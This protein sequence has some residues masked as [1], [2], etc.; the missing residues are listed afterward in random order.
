M[1]TGKTRTAIELCNAVADLQD[2]R[3]LVLYFRLRSSWSTDASDL[4]LLAKALTVANNKEL[5]DRPVTFGE[6]A[7]AVRRDGFTKVILHMDE[8][9]LDRPFISR[10][11]DGCVQTM[12]DFRTD[13]VT[14]IP[15]LSGIALPGRKTLPS[16]ESIQGFQIRP[17]EKPEDLLVPFAD[18]INVPTTCVLSSPHLKELLYL[19][20]GA[21]NVVEVMTDVIL[22]E[23]KGNSTFKADLQ[24]NLEQQH[25]R[26]VYERTLLDLAGTYGPMRWHSLIVGPRPDIVTDQQA[27]DRDSWGKRSIHVLECLFLE[28]FMGS[29]IQNADAR[30]GTTDMTDPLFP[31]YRDCV[32]AG[33]LSI[34]EFTKTLS[35]P[36]MGLMVLDQL[37]R[38][39]PDGINDPFS[40]T[41]Q[42]FEFI[43]AASLYMRLLLARNR[44][45]SDILARE[46][47]PGASTSG[48]DDLR[49]KVPDSLRFEWMGAKITGKAG[50]VIR[51]AADGKGDPLVVSPGL[52]AMAM[53]NE[54]AVDA[55]A[56]LEATDGSETLLVL[57]QSKERDKNVGNGKEAE[58]VL[59][60]GTIISTLLPGMMDIGNQF[61]TQFN[62][63]SDT[64]IILDVFSDRGEPSDS[65]ARLDEAPSGVPYFITRRPQLSSSAGPAFAHLAGA[66]RQRMMRE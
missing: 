37:V 62:L 19:C 40:P 51:K 27:R 21:P 17:F 55:L 54:T 56:V 6:V 20:A 13:S 65:Q 16:H 3:P 41:W 61:K 34:D 8:V 66:K 11:V 39:L 9:Q 1:G 36:L 42:S 48:L 23:S 33:M 63:P 44:K 45:Q 2:A 30:V 29:R 60:N 57:N 53:R 5:F 24:T 35:M 10:I 22:E 64:T 7:A 25:A 49:V 15:V 47:R 31:T 28:C 4:D 32:N 14:V 59:F 52:I 18:R 26:T 50:D 43:G 58:T 38:L 46:L 12:T